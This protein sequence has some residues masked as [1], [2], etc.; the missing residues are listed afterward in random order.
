MSSSKHHIQY[1]SNPFTTAWN[2]IQKIFTVNPQS[3]VG[4]TVAILAI[5]AALGATAVV[6]ALATFAFMAK[7]YPRSDPFPGQSSLGYFHYMSDSTVFGLW[8]VGIVVGALLLTLLQALQM[9][10][11]IASARNTSVTF[12]QVFGPSLK[13][14]LPLLG[15]AG[16]ITV[17]LALVFVILGLASIAAPIVLVLLGLAAIISLVYVCFRLSFASYAIVDKNLGPIAA[18]KHSWA[19]TDG[20]VVDIIG[21]GAA[22]YALMAVPSIILTALSKVSEGVPVLVNIFDVLGLVLELVLLVVATMPMAERYVQSQA[23]Y[24]K[25]IEAAPTS[26]F[27]FV[28]IVLVLVLM[29][30]LNALT[31]EPTDG[32]NTDPYSSFMPALQQSADDSPQGSSKAY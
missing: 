22:T 9:R 1:D 29:P 18:I 15:L 31:A 16:L 2:G 23:V 19:S 10:F 6:F 24:D 20:R 27:N 5:C 3:F 12:R 4:V 11:T 8:G 7:H 28:A 13:Y 17:S 32:N 14:L 25:E 30:I 21:V 26:G